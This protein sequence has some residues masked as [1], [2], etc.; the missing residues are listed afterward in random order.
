MENHPEPIR[1]TGQRLDKNNFVQSYINNINMLIHI[2]RTGQKCC[3]LDK[4]KD[5]ARLDKKSFVQSVFNNI[6]NLDWTKILL[7]KKK[8]VQSNIL[9]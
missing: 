5:W 4:K 8:I 3:G 2:F 9:K 6:N 1:R 7:D